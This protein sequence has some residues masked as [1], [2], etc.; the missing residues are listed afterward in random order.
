M[1]C[2]SVVVVSEPHSEDLNPFQLFAQECWGPLRSGLLGLTPEDGVTI[3]ERWESAACSGSQLGRYS[4]HTD[5]GALLK[6][7]LTCRL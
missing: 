2:S 6:E 1:T 3:Q 5:V 4:Q 7:G